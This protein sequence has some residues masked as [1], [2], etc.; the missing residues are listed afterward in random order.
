MRLII[1]SGPRIGEEFAIPED[2]VKIGRIATCIIRLD[3]DRLSREHAAV[4]LVKGR[5]HVVDLGSRNGTTLN[6]RKIQQAPLAPGDRIGVG[7]VTLLYVEEPPSSGA[8]TPPPLTDS[9][10]TP[11][12]D[13]AGSDSGSVAPG[14]AAAAGAAAPEPARAADGSRTPLVIGLYAIAL[15]VVFFAVSFATRALLAVI[16]PAR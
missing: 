10:A 12:P 13:L 9:M 3:D 5:P 14:P 15:A 6:G 7:A 1:E 16:D 4:R 11:D 2:G 8:L